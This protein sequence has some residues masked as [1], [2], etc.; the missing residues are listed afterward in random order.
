MKKITIVALL[1]LGTTSFVE[2]QL[3]KTS[4]NLTVRDELGNTVKEA[5]VTL[6]ETQED[7][8]AEKN[9]VMTATTDEKG[10]VKFKELKA[11]PYYVI[12]RKGD[13]DNAGAGEQVGK[14]EANKI[15]K[16]TIIIR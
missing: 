15:N 13:M 6:F 16:A 7:Y 8:D 4:L 3:I 9:P 10:V 2:A 5:T 1:L 11:I 14:L 12:V